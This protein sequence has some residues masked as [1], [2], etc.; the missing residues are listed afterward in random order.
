MCLLVFWV[1]VALAC[2]W[3]GPVVWCV[4]GLLRL[5]GCD[6]VVGGLRCLPVNSVG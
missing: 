5:L 6:G 1:L 4:V 3:F 2:C